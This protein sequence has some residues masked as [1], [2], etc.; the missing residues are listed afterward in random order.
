MWQR[1]IIPALQNITKTF[2]EKLSYFSIINEDNKA[3]KFCL[4]EI[5]F[6]NGEKIF[7][8]VKKTKF[9]NLYWEEALANR[10]GRSRGSIVDRPSS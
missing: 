6:E 3:S 9:E 10:D 2:N 5:H 8:K 1:D 7:D 4:R